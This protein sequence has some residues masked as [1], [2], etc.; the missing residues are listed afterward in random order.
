V[1]RNVFKA[2][3]TSTSFVKLQKTLLKASLWLIFVAGFLGVVIAQ[4]KPVSSAA[5]Q[6][7]VHSAASAESYGV[8][9]VGVITSKDP[10]KSVV[11]IKEVKS[12]KVMALKVGYKLLGKYPLVKVSAKSIRIQKD[13]TYVELYKDKF[14]GGTGSVAKKPELKSGRVSEFSEDGMTRQT[15]DDEIDIEITSS[16]RDHMVK[17]KLQSILMSAAATPYLES[18]KV[19]GFK[20]TDITPGSIFEKAGF[21]NGD[22]VTTINDIALVSAPGAIKVLRG[23]KEAQSVDVQILRKGVT[24]DMVISVK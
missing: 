20:I 13:D 4:E 2:E 16:Y 14:A 23:L 15:R 3:Y 19:R 9:M 7:V 5:T 8:I 21:M 18:G 1:V 11:L 6:A 22:I 12:K 24:M 17:N 10:Q